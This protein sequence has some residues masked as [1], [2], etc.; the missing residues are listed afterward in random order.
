MCVPSLT[1]VVFEEIVPFSPFSAL[2][3]H[4]YSISFSHA[5][6]LLEMGRITDSDSNVSGIAISVRGNSSGKQE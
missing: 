5:A 3:M 2:W 6:C 4:F 1:T